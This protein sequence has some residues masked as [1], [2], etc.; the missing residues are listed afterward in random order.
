MSFTRQT[1][2]R[3]TLIRLGSL[4]LLLILLN[5]LVG[6]GAIRYTKQA[7][8]QDLATLER[9]EAAQAQ[10]QS[11]L[12]H[13]KMQVQEWKNILLRGDEADDLAKY[14]AAFERELEIVEQKLV[15]LAANAAAAGLVG[16]GIDEAIAIHQSLQLEYDTALADF[17]AR[18]GTDPRRTDAEVRGIDR[19]LTQ[20]IDHIG[21]SAAS[22]AASLRSQIAQ[23]AADR[24]ENI[25]FYSSIAAFV[26]A[27]LVVLILLTALS[28]IDKR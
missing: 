15:A 20:R 28:S 8:L 16:L 10:A 3:A 27:A 19:E 11:A 6:L 4:L 25:L 13:F 17:V 7:A 1:Q 14:R 23:A 18:G 9:I 21:S 24:Y 2:V 5:S 26:I 12:V 22:Q